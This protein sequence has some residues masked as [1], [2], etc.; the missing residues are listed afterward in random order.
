MES[1][2]SIAAPPPPPPPRPRQGSSG[3]GGSGSSGSSGGSGGG[4]GGSGG[5]VVVSASTTALLH[6]VTRRL[7]AKDVPH[8]AWT[9]KLAG[10]SGSPTVVLL[11]CYS[12]QPHGRK[13]RCSRFPVAA[14]RQGESAWRPLVAKLFQQ[15][16]SKQLSV[17]QTS[18]VM[19]H[20]IAIRL[21]GEDAIVVLGDAYTHE[22]IITMFVCGA[23]AGAC[24]KFFVP[25]LLDVFVATHKDLGC[26]VM[27]HEG[28]PLQQWKHGASPE[29]LMHVLLQV[30]VLLHALQRHLH[31]QHKDLHDG[32]VLVRRGVQ[33]GGRYIV[34]N[35]VLDM[36]ACD[37]VVRMIDFQF[38]TVVT[39]THECFV[40]ADMFV[41]GNASDAS[42]AWGR[43]LQTLVTA[44]ARSLHAPACLRVLKHAAAALGAPLALPIDKVS[45][46]QPRQFLLRMFGGKGAFAVARYLQRDSGSTDAQPRFVCGDACE[47]DGV[48]KSQTT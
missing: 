16:T 34:D 6:T 2:N 12:A 42:I 14:Q 23:P 8:L 45:C 27:T 28:T 22:A 4:S 5:S 46:V 9:R 31:F 37:F 33:T 30:A 38:A 47:G 1:T 3:S 35:L 36:P 26:M 32:N 24:W 13:T 25:R 19:E 17:T 21:H 40:R 41:A 15:I 18:K 29:D 10:G 43:D 44:L 20:W 11:Q 39:P 7:G 48:G